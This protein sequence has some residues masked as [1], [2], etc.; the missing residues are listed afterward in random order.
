MEQKEEEEEAGGDFN[1][2]KHVVQD[3]PEKNNFLFWS[4]NVLQQFKQD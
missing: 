2:S 3:V 4:F 1:A